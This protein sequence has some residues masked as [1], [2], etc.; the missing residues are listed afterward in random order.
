MAGL[1]A[2]RGRN[3]MTDRNPPRLATWLIEKLGFS[4]RNP[5]L[6]GDL[7]EEFHSG[8]SRTWYWRQTAI[9]IAKGFRT[10]GVLRDPSQRCRGIL[11][12]PGADRLHFLAPSFRARHV[13]GGYR[14]HDA[15][16]RLHLHDKE[17]VAGAAG[18][19][20][21]DD[22]LAFDQLVAARMGHPGVLGSTDCSG[23]RHG[24]S[25]LAGSDDQGADRLAR[26]TFTP[27][28]M[29]S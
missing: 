21:R 29:K 2:T 6:I 1:A 25:A 18:S 20:H 10:S 23:L 8:R 14:N 5:A 11:G 22:R 17:M 15:G 27:Q 3:G 9:M 4:R 13:L 19:R 12:F 24:G 7:L 28:R 16:D 26:P